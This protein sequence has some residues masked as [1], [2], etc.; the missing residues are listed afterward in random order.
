MAYQR[1]L[2]GGRTFPLGSG[3]D[4]CLCTAGSQAYTWCR[5]PG[6]N[7]AHS[8]RSGTLRWERPSDIIKGTAFL[9]SCKWKCAC[10][11][12]RKL[13]S[14]SFL[15]LTLVV[16]EKCRWTSVEER[17]KWKSLN[18]PVRESCR[19]PLVEALPAETGCQVWK[20]TVHYSI[21]V[22]CAVF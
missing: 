20:I 18:C 4:T 3:S 10:E 1:S 16:R 13:Q 7:N 22:E 21:L 17:K 12:W 8:P 19:K 2:T 11:S 5:S 9:S 15:I 6:W 14:V